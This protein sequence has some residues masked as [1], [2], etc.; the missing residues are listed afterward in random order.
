MNEA[1]QQ[2]ITRLGK[3]L[4]WGCILT[5]CSIFA[6]LCWVFLIGCFLLAYAMIIVFRAGMSRSA[7]SNAIT[8]RTFGSAIIADQI[9]DYFVFV[10]IAGCGVIFLLTC[11]YVRRA[12]TQR[13]SPGGS[14]PLDANECAPR[15]QPRTAL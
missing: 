4:C 10:A 11:L 6:F 15:R 5:A 1:G 14:A 2:M 7:I 8:N 13:L 12:V 9:G 3:V